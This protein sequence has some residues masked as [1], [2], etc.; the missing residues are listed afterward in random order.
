MLGVSG[1]PVLD[2]VGK[3]GDLGDWSDDK[4]RT[5][6]C[7]DWDHH[8]MFPL[9]DGLWCHRISDSFRPALLYVSVIA[10][11][12]LYIVDLGAIC[13]SKLSLL[14]ALSLF[15]PPLFYPLYLNLFDLFS[16]S[17]AFLCAAPPSNC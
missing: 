10:R 4:L 2:A 12:Y 13:S 17:R 15:C 1:T 3:S 16:L 8:S 7:P 11:L 9:S 14:V 6:K 5:L